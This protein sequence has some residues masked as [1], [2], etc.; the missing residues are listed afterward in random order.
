MEAGERRRRARRQLAAIEG[1]DGH[2]GTSATSVSGGPRRFEWDIIERTMPILLERAQP[3]VLGPGA[4]DNGVLRQPARVGDP[5]GVQYRLCERSAQLT[6]GPRAGRTVAAR[7][8]A[9][10]R[11]FAGGSPRG[12]PRLNE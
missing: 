6:P 8:R 9:R 10:P 12:A 7:R 5:H 1:R 2:K 11:S 3:I 4:I